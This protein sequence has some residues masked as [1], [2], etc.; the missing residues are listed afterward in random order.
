MK[1]LATNYYQLTIRYVWGRDLSGTLDGA[2]G[3]S[4]YG[5]ISRRA[6]KGA[7]PQRRGKRRRFFNTKITEN[8]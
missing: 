8:T 6:A 4:R 2:G 3:L 7:E 5:A 1:P